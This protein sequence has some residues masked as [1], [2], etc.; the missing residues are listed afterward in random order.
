M[1]KIAKFTVAVFV[2]LLAMTTAS[3]IIVAQS[4]NPRIR[5]DGEFVQITHNYLQPTIIDNRVLVP[6]R[7]AIEG[8][9]F[10]L[11]W[12]KQTQAVVLFKPGLTVRYEI[13]SYNIY[14]NDDV[15]LLDVPP[16]IINGSVMIPLRAFSETTGMEI[17][18]DNENLI[19]DIVTTDESQPE[20]ESISDDN[21]PENLPKYIPSSVE[22]RPEENFGFW[23]PMRFRFVFYSV[24]SQIINLV[25]APKG[26]EFL[27]NIDSE[28]NIFEE[29]M[30]LMLFVQHFDIP[31]EDFDDVVNSLHRIRQDQAARGVIDLNDEQF[32]LPN[33]DII[34]TFDNEIIRYYYRRE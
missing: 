20:R 33:A 10:S 30:I 17:H 32:E 27:Q 14:V 22:L 3:S 24:P 21:W 29:V 26:Q 11:K 23:F 19:A 6:L 31:R 15:V 7:V 4:K 18:W 5:I 25:D 13:D 2:V 12:D 16:Q 1:R 34:Y 8:L 9:G 28:G